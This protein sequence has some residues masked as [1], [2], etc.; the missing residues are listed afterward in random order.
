MPIPGNLLT[1][2]MAVMPHTD[3]DRALTTALSL[4]VPFWPQ[5]PNYSYYEDMYVQAAEHFPG[6]LLDL[7]KRTLR[8]SQEKFIEEL[9]AVMARF[10]DPSYF[11]I[12]ETYSA[13]YHRFLAMDLSDRPAIRGQLEGP[14][15]FGF[16]ILDEND[17][18]ILFDD[19]V[20]PFMFEFMAKRI[21]V[22]LARLLKLNPNAFMF[23]DEPGLQFIFSAMSG[24]GD[25]KAKGDMDDFF[26][27]I[28][29][30]R[31]IHLCGNPDWDFL[32]NLDLDVLSMDLYTN[33]EIFASYGPSIRRFLDRGGVIVWGIVP[34]GFENFEKEDLPS[35]TAQLESVWE[36]LG[37]K[38]IDRDFMISRSM[39]S[40][41]TCC[42]VNP[43]KEKTVERAFG[44][45]KEMSRRLRDKYRPA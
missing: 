19:T 10:D 25:I 27:M 2:A 22:Q 24:Y 41:A 16:N 42:L 17:R 21:N 30:P 26:A 5:L 45:V 36:I 33:R 4:D 37:K 29:R 35:L 9:E 14:V 11:D 12:S 3:V 38:G 23:V 32:L 40:P 31:G 20:R 15:S 28:D 34:T 39:L 43:D 18:P 44:V 6:I 7:D 13:V 8:F 1:T